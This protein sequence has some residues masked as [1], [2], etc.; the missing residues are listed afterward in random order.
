M[1][2]RNKKKTRFEV[3]QNKMET[4][5]TFKSTFIPKSRYVINWKITNQS[6]R[7]LLCDN[8]FLGEVILFNRDFGSKLSLFD[9]MTSSKVPIKPP[10]FRVIV[11]KVLTF[12][13]DFFMFIL[14]FLL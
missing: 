3:A 6:P 11:R 5:E 13:D 2:Q 14:S 1:S 4:K 12:D 7:Y 9:L 10:N 8:Y